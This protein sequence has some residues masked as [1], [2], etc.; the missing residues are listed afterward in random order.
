[1]F[2]GV[3]VIY[4]IDPHNEEEVPQHDLGTIGVTHDGRKFRYARNSSAAALTAG[5]LLASAAENTTNQS[6]VVAAASIGDMSITTTGNVT[7]TA[8]QYANGYVLGTGEASTG[9]GILYRIKSHPAASA[10]VCT[11]QLYEPIKVAMTATTQVDFIADPYAAVIQWPTTAT[12]TPVGVAYIA[13]T[14]SYY[15]WIQTGGIGVCWADAGGAVAVGQSVVASNQTAG[16]VEDTASTTQAIV[17]T[18]I[19]G[20][21]QAECGPVYLLLD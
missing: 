1:M 12:G 4:G 16:C 21:A 6:V 8:N 11:F 7:V 20:I 2:T 19:T 5:E 15:G 3:P 13:M 17:G 14:A 18:A 10:A 9:N